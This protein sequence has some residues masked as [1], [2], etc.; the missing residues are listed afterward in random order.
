MVFDGRLANR[1]E[2]AST[3]NLEK[4]RLIVLSDAEVAM[5]CWERW[6]RLSL[7]H[8]IGE[9]AFILWDSAENQLLAA[10]DHFGAR[11]LHYH[12]NSSR[13]VIAS[14]PKCIHALGDLPRELDQQKIADALSQLYHDGERTFFKGVK[15]IPPAGL[16]TVSGGAL[17]VQKYYELRENIRPVHY[18]SDAQYV[19]AARELF[20]TSVRASI[21]TSGPV[22][23]FLSGGLDSS[24]MSAVAA[25]ILREKGKKLITY[26]SIPE[27]GWDQRVVKGF[28][29]DESPFV[30]DIAEHIPS[31]EANFV[32]GAGL[33]HYH[34]Q[35]ELLLAL[36]MPVR[37]ALNLQWTHAILEQAKSRGISVMLQ[38]AFGNAT[39][40]QD[41]DGVFGEL[42]RNGAM[43]RLFSELNAISKGPSHFLK[44]TLKHLVFP[45]GPSWL[46]G[47]K[48]MLR[49]RSRRETHWRSFV[50]VAPGFAEEMNIADRVKDAGYHYSGGK[51]EYSRPLWIDSF[52]SFLTEHG[53]IMQGLRA[54]Y[55]IEIRD[56]FADRRLVEWSFG[57]P[58]EQFW[59]RG[60]SRWLIRRMMDGQL[61]DSVVNAQKR[62]FQTADWHFRMSR[63]LPA[64]RRD[65][66]LISQDPDLSR[67]V[68]VDLIRDLLD[69]WPDATV[70]DR[71]DDRIFQLPVVVPM[72]LQVARFVQREK[73]VNLPF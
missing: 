26:T 18:K 58:E 59:R 12:A 66:E 33:G 19:E 34:K 22:G 70:S 61:P 17:N 20:E 7:N 14:G 39:L 6:G 32:D 63:D 45:M 49:G 1:D 57:V 64:M 42:F 28:Y 44:N 25:Q 24:A 9:F 41:G 38:G 60:V 16:I 46:W 29:G 23:A 55:G 47:A 40:S 4:H 52:S 8:W 36:E 43:L 5:L 72:T 65:L 53:D 13:I 73:G 21:R 37:N 15:R 54:M 10:R 48:E 3:L 51:P 67:M 62:G 2:L 35:E 31:L 69:D 11:T 68:N 27:E 56:P 71:N 30:R 50:S